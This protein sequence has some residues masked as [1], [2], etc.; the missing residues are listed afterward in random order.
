MSVVRQL[1]QAVL[2]L[3][4][5]GWVGCCGPA[6]ATTTA[7]ELTNSVTVREQPGAC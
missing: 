2:V 5:L 3:G 4:L 1:A 6:S 7:P